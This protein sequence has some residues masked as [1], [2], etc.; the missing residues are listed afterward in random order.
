MDLHTKL[1]LLLALMHAYDFKKYRY[2]NYFDNQDSGF[3][4]N[5]HENL[6]SALISIEFLPLDLKPATN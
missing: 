2:N 3:V 4:K 6:P 1:H 5:G